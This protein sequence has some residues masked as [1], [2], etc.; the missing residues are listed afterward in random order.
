MDNRRDIT[1]SVETPAS[2]L[3]ESTAWRPRDSYF[4]GS[5]VSL[6]VDGNID[7]ADVYAGVNVL[8]PGAEIPLHW[9]DAGEFQFILSGTGLALAPAADRP[10]RAHDAVFSPAG[11][12]HGF[13]N[14]S[15]Q[16]LTIL[17]VYPSPGGSTPSLDL[18]V[19]RA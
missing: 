7:R 10:I 5:T 16:P 1:S 2:I 19:G 13:R 3:I 15:L 8:A 6:I 4:D 9:H 18:G 12:A 11:S 14:T 17:F